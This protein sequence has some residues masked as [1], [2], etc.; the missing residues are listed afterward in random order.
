MGRIAF[1]ILLFLAFPLVADSQSSDCKI[2]S[3]SFACPTGLKLI[4]NRDPAYEVFTGKDVSV[5]VASAEGDVDVSA[6]VSDLVKTSLAELFPK[7]NHTFDWKPLRQSRVF[8]RFE[9]DRLGRQGFNGTNG[10]AVDYRVIHY[11]S[12]QLLVGYVAAL[13]TGDE[14]KAVFDRNLPAESAATIAGC[15][16]SANVI[17][18]ITHE[19]SAKDNSPCSVGVKSGD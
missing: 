1:L 13:G 14:M 16:A 5:F 17:Y 2:G 3:T 8:S 18:S 12:I 6:L 10:V 15:E 11:K 7:A 4:Q 9:T 19:K